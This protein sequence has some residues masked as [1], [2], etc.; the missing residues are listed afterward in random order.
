[1][2]SEQFDREIRYWTMAALTNEL[3][4]RGLLSM[5][6]ADN[7]TKMMATICPSMIASISP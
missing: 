3:L 1:M 5:E 6:D 2:N 7:I 4:K